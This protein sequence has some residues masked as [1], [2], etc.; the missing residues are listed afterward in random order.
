[1]NR[2]DVIYFVIAVNGFIIYNKGFSHS[3]ELVTETI[4]NNLMITGNTAISF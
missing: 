2:G 1:M 3:K 4:C